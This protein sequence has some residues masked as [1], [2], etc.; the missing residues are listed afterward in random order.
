MQQ[1]RRIA[2]EHLSN[3]FS[4][5]ELSSTASDAGTDETCPVICANEIFFGTSIKRGLR[6]VFFSAPPEPS[7]AAATTTRKSA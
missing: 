2:A 4:T 1:A 7:L 5:G 3:S 6:I